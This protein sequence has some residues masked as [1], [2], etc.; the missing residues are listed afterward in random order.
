M[1]PSTVRFWA[2]LL[3]F[4]PSIFCSSFTLYHLLSTRRLRRALNNHVIAILLVIC[5]ISQVTFYPWILY[6][7]HHQGVW[8]RSRIFCVIW[9]FLDWLLYVLHTMLFAWAT[10][11]RHIIIFHDGW[12]STK[13]KRFLVHYLPIILLVLYLSIFYTIM[14][15][16]PPCENR[17]RPAQLLC[18]FPCLYD[19]NAISLSDF[20]INQLVPILTIALFSIGLL[21]RVLRQK[22]RMHRTINW[23]KHRKMVIQTLSISL[24]YLTI[25]L[26][27]AIVYILGNVYGLSTSTVTDLSTCTVFFSYFILLFFPFVSAF[28]LPGL[29]TRLKNIF[30]LPLR[31]RRLSQPILTVTACGSDS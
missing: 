7:Y 27:Y 30:H 8:G 3:T 24:L 19:K 31:A 4:I 23:R 25:L 11:E 14:Y 28:S 15:F 29:I 1:I 6:Y 12:V 22:Y 13:R 20:I 26:P 9:G 21:V 2:F 18:I 17:I 5:L 16:F 10:V